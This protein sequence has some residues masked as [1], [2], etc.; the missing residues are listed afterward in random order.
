M[1]YKTVD[2]TNMDR[3]KPYRISF[4]KTGIAAA[5]IIV[6]L[7]SS[8]A[9][10]QNI[11]HASDS[12][13]IDQVIMD[14]LKNNDRLAA[15]QYMEQSAR[16]K[17]GPAGA[18][19]DP[20]LM[21]GV[22]NL[23]TSLDFQSDD[24][25][26]KMI[27]LSQNIPYSGYKGLQ[28]KAAKSDAEASTAERHSAELDLISAA[29]TAFYDLYYK[30]LI[31]NELLRQK[32]LFGQIVSSTLGKLKT[33]Q[34]GQEEYLSAES[35][36]WRVESEI[37]SA[38]QEL[39]ES[40]YSLNALR[41]IKGDTILPPL[42]GPSIMEIPDSASVWLAASY[43]HYPELRK[44]Q[45]QSESYSFSAAASRRMA[46]PMLTL[47]G[48]YG[49][50]EG[51]GMMGP[52]DNM[53]SI[54]ADISLPFLSGRQQKNMARSMLAMSKSSQASANQLR[55]DIDARIR[56]LHQRALR[57]SESRDI[58]QNKIVPTSEETFRS[59]FSG[60]TS[61]LISY[62]ELINTAISLYRDHI[63]L[64]QISNQ[65][66]QTMTEVERYIAD[67][68]EIDQKTDNPLK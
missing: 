25:T 50:R 43:E 68:A 29:K 27:G 52:R 40:R 11:Q 51:I 58:Y 1:S 23:P 65:L 10:S 41:G 33:N 48:S 67:P 4:L 2:L 62:T 42:A 46:W 35:N 20:M 56:A 32:D 18:W 59:A 5:L 14:V 15:A 64:D 63:T 45:S 39:D 8:S 49:L 28:A 53:I 55:T 19:D 66:A 30:N 60:Y 17:I 6:C 47:S 24:M 9:L 22:T 12:L 31:L 54:Q 16:A 7:L 36:L 44:L 37:L 57:L 61:N 21:V 13:Y 3:M 38:R 34:A 26:M